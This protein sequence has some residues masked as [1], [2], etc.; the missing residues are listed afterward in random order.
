MVLFALKRIA[1]KFH[2]SSMLRK[3]VETLEHLLWIK[4]KILEKY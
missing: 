4:N 3:N 2:V 1:N